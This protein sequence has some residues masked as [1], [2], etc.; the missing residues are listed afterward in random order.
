M[1]ILITGA[2][3]QLGQCWA[4]LGADQSQ[5]TA[6][7]LHGLSRRELDITD[8]DAVNRIF[9][10]IRPDVVVNAAAWTDVEAAERNV[11]QAIAVNALGAANIAAAAEDYDAR[12]IHISSDYVFDG[13]GTH[14]IAEDAT[15]RPLNVYGASKQAGEQAVLSESPNAM[16]LRTSW[17]YSCHGSN[18]VKSVLRRARQQRVLDVVDNQTGCPT[19]A[20]DLADAIVQLAQ[21]GAAAGTYHYAGSDAM[22]WFDFACLIIEQAVRYDASWA[23]VQVRRASDPP[24]GIVAPRPAYTVLSCDRIQ[25]LGIQRYGPRHRLEQVVGS[26]LGTS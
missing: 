12:L 26:V 21:S 3:G 13:N 19:W 5:G 17:L 18:F 15:P 1:K 8:A 25:A 23:D 7:T 20:G 4:A 24:A 11:D 9:R 10:Q 14:P 6:W 22:T 16:I 2:E